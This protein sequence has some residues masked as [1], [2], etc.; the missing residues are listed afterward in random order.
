MRVDASRGCAIEHGIE[1]GGETFAVEMA[2]GIGEHRYFSRAPTG[3][4]S[5]KAASTGAP[6]SSEA[7]TIMPFDSIPRSFRGCRLATITTLRPTSFSGFVSL[8]DPGDDRARL[9]LTDIDLQVQ[10]FVGAL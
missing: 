10:K 1:I 6:P 8:R 5:R 9:R 2:V 3:T 7:A 4:S